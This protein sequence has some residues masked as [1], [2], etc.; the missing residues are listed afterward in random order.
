MTAPDALVVGSGPNGLAAAVAL[1][2]AGLRV[3][4]REGADEPGGGARTL[5][6]T[7]PGFLHD[8][9]SA[10]HPLAAASPFFR[11]LPLAAHGLEL[12]A[13]PAAVAHP[14]DDGTA[15]LLLRDLGDTGATLGPD[16][17]AWA[18]L[19]GPLSLRFGPLVG[20]LLG[21]VLH[22]PRH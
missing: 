6:L 13:P 8:H 19:L 17:T 11:T 15:A 22:R 4:V 7:L 10:V 12:L 9:C 18:R 14:F 5:P 20:E 1:S 21:P 2:Q 16:A 3:A